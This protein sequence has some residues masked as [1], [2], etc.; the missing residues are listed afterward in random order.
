MQK[1]ERAKIV[2][3][4]IRDQE[5]DLAVVAVDP[6]LMICQH[7]NRIHP[8]G[9]GMFVCFECLIRLVRGA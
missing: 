1:V 9:G 6:G 8:L 4:S 5:V 2:A 7:E 3:R